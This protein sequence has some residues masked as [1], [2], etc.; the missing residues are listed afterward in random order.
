MLMTLMALVVSAT[1]DST[2]LFIG[3]QT[4]LHLRAT[5][6]QGEEVSMPVLAN[7]LVPGVEIVDRTLVD[8]T[9]LKDGRVQY[10]QYI[11]LTSFQDSLFYIAPLPFASGG[12][13]LWS[14]ALTLNVVQPFEIDST[15]M[16]IT[17]IKGI[18]KA[19]IWWWGIFRWILLTLVLIGL[20]VGLYY[21]VRF[22]ESRKRSSIPTLEPA[23]P[24]R[25]A[26]EV[27]LEKLELIR[28]QKLWQQGQIKEY[29]TQLT[30]VVREY[31]ARRFAVS[32]TEQTSDETLSAMRPILSAQREL[33][34]D[35]RK[36]LTLA[37]LVKFAKWNT[38]PDENEK[39]L[40]DAYTFVH[41]TTPR[42]EENQNA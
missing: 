14:E 19:P 39:C 35:L 7:E 29:Y 30:D 25:P 32:S 15:D 4:D 26:E 9:L 1:I 37:D 34:D 38:T 5:C 13:T 20:G 18:E 42:P 33:Y 27:A 40:R 23:Q 17:D 3:D 16:A 8:T 31:I 11:T 22:I 2:T 28:T 10:N 12:D 24:L 21:L 36:M 41:E 6:E